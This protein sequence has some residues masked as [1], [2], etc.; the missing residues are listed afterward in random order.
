MMV[1]IPSQS[2]QQQRGVAGAG[3]VSFAVNCKSSQFCPLSETSV[4]P[5]VR[6]HSLPPPN[7]QIVILHR[8]QLKLKS[9][10]GTG[11]VGPIHQNY[12]KKA[13][14]YGKEIEF[15]ERQTAPTIPQKSHA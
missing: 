6:P 10:I 14:L 2:C 1:V 5:E 11:R 3:Q 13:G 15:S 4:A 7:A 9:P 12:D 8:T